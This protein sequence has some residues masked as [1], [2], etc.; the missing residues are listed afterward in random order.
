[1]C[2]WPPSCGHFDANAV[3]CDNFDYY[4]CKNPPS[5]APFKSP[6]RLLLKALGRAALLALPAY[7]S[8]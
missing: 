5:S 7:K 6:I 3:H 8:D 4:S 2:I 1:M